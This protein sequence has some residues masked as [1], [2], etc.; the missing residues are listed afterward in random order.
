MG[1]G[2]QGFRSLVQL[3]IAALN[4]ALN[5]WLIR[6]YSWKG[7]AAATL[8]C[9]GAMAFCF[10]LFL[11]RAARDAVSSEG[12]VDVSPA[13]PLAASPAVPAHDEVSAV[14]VTYGDRSELCRQA[15][16]GALDCG[17][18]RVVIVDNGSTESAHDALAAIAVARGNE[19]ELDLVGRNLGSAGGFGRGIEM[20]LRRVECTEVWLLDDDTVPDPTA[21]DEL[22]VWRTS[23][24]QST[25]PEVALVSYRPARL[26]QRLLVRGEPVEGSTLALRRSYGLRRR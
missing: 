1:A 2:R 15:V 4:I 7:A 9:E 21:L 10:V 25:R 17:V 3:A 18:G 11:H 26:F 6:A 24:V 13:A 14:I 20:A 22:L 19:V 8:L 16:R 23:L 5:L 12:M